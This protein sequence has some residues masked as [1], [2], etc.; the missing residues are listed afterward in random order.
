MDATATSLMTSF[1][2]ISFLKLVSATSILS[3]L[4]S[5]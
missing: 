4:T 5:T 1:R 3:H 2:L